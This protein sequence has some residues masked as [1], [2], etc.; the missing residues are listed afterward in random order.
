M[1]EDWMD[2]RDVDISSTGGALLDT[3]RAAMAESRRRRMVA[4]LNAHPRTRQ[5]LEAE[6]GKA[7][8]PDELTAEFEVEGFLAPFAVVK[9]HGTDVVGSVLFQHEPRFYFA[10]EVYTKEEA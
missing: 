6:Y 10:F 8:T 2:L 1:I 5:E 4:E 7:W 9:R 3:L